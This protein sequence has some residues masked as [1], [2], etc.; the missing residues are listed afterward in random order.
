[1][2]VLKRSWRVFSARTFG[3]FLGGMSITSM[4]C[5]VGT[6]TLNV[7]DADTSS[8]TIA[9]WSANTTKKMVGRDF[10]QAFASSMA[11]WTRNGG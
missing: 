4:E 1:M 9:R 5:S 11:L 2:L 6:P 10:P 7:R 3:T 8:A